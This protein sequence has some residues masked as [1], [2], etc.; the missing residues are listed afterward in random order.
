MFHTLIEELEPT[1]RCLNF[2][3]ETITVI[4]YVQGR[5]NYYTEQ[6]NFVAKIFN[7][8]KAKMLK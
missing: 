8:L 3:L 5:G 2:S 7:C 1:A 4:F 6:N